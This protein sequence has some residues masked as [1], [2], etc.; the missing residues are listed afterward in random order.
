VTTDKDFKPGFRRGARQT[1]KLQDAYKAVFTMKQATPE[2]LQMVLD[3]LAEFCGYFAVSPR[4][5]SAEETNYDNGQRS[6]FARILSLIELSDYELNR[7][8]A[9]AL[10]EM[11]ISAQEGER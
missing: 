9:D 11:Q 4:G 2:A 10:V 5:A 8:R 1:L 3:D 6:V 7:L